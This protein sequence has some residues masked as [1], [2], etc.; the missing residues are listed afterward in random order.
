MASGKQLCVHMICKPALAA[1]LLI[2]QAPELGDQQL[3]EQTVKPV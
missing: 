3:P 1:A 2:E